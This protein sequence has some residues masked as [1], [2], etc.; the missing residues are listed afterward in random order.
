MSLFKK[1]SQ[2][3]FFLF[4]SF[5]GLSQSYD[6]GKVTV[7]ELQEKEHPVE[8]NAEAAVLFDIGKSYFEFNVNTGFR[9]ITEVTTK[10][11]VYKKEG[12][13]FADI[14]IPVYVGGDER[15]TVSFTKAF[16]YNLVNGKIEKT[17][18]KS[19]GEFT[20]KV[21]KFWNKVKVSMPDVK[22]GSV[23]EYK[24][25]VTSPFFTNLPEW[26]FQKSIPVN[27][28]K[29]V[30]SVPEY[31][32]Y[33]PRVKGYIH[34]KISTTTK[35][36]THNYTEKER[37]GFTVSR[38]NFSNEK[39]TYQEAV[40]TYITEMLPSMK[41]EDFVA[42]IKDYTS[43][44]LHE[45][46]YIKYPNSPIKS[47]SSSWD[48]VCKTIYDTE[49]FGSELKKTGYFEKDIEA[50]L[51]NKTLKE[52]KINAILHF[53]K[54]QVKW[55]G[56]YG[57]YCDDGVRTAY[58][59]KSGNIAEINLMLVAM[60]RY[61]GFEANPVLVSTRSNGV[62]LFPSR[63]AFNYVVCAVE[64]TNGLIM[65]DASDLN[66]SL[67]ILPTRVLNW[68]GRLIRREGT[69]G[70]IELIPA[71]VSKEN[72][73]GLISIDKEGNINGKLRRQYFDYNAYHFR[74]NYLNYNKDNYLESLEK[75]LSDIEI[76]DYKV[77][78]ENDLSKP[79]VEEF[80]FKH[81]DLVEIIGD[82]MYFSPLFFYSI[83]ENPF[84][85]DKRDYPID[86]VY[87]Q[88]DKYVLTVTIPEG[89]VVE[90][91]PQNK[92]FAVE[93]NRLVY[94]FNLSASE[95]KIQMTA[96]LLMNESL[97]TPDYY[98]DLKDFFK[99]IVENQTEKIVL[100]KS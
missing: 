84:K 38:T 19:D 71:F 91:L 20:E 55:N 65:L 39:M 59:N 80:S 25:T 27:Y 28:S 52:E 49:N 74:N 51:Q 93:N 81:S 22:E 57:I 1:S 46:S 64:T 98:V 97:I 78:N 62:P 72:T 70:F 10:I 2:I 37:S 50:L 47:L 100:K 5:S 96:T 30:T 99:Q 42:N 89:Y 36:T 66:S 40:N 41:D 73:Q 6:L 13:S 67:N 43:G 33:N 16:T 14:A 45:L 69:S 35:T 94:R 8:K 92:A 29:F 26:Y 79:I 34:P 76:E 75:K 87:P 32:V 60:L 31:F 54:G 24:Y 23:I 82:K 86:F 11:K 18:L 44:V 68:Q 9:L 12:Y 63:T 17:K 85:V 83:T 15:E 48:D 56:Y 58:K 90:S 4:I 7:A 88:E 3:Y 21:N 53:V 95:G 61:A 77:T